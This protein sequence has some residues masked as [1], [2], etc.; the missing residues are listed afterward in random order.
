MPGFNMPH[1]QHLQSADDLVTP[2][3]KIRAGFI[4]V[5]LEKNHQATPYIE[6]AK[7]LKVAASKMKTP[8]DLLILSELRPALL[9]AAGVSDKA[10]NHLQE[11]DQ[12]AAILGLIEN[13]LEPAGDDFVDELVFRFLLT[14]GDSLG[15]RMRNLAGL[16]AERQLTRAL[17][18]TLTIRG[19][20]FSWLS[21]NSRTWRVGDADN[22]GVDVRIRGL[23]WMVN[24]Q[25]RTLI[26]NLTVPVVNKNV[27]LCLLHTKPDSVNFGSAKPSTHHQVEAYIALGELKGGIDPAGADEHWKTANSALGRIREAFAAGGYSPDLFFLAAAIAPAMAEEIYRQLQ[28]GQ[29]ANAANITDD[30]QLYSFCEWLTSL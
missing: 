20:L 4:Q 12:I 10:T 22:P 18:A 26:Y 8:R 6:E 25:H 1:Q 14:K 19:K 28:T 21:R 23:H 11:S 27:D 13:F 9:T 7:A 16:L 3:S 24:N 17:I 5:A 2:Y 29:L 30:N 15:G